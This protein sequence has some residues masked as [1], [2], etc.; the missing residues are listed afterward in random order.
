MID[1]T[2][3]VIPKHL[4]ALWNRRF[5][6]E[7]T[8][9]Y[10]QVLRKSIASS[11]KDD[12]LYLPVSLVNLA[13]KLE[14]V[15]RDLLSCVPYAVCPTCQ[16]EATQACLMCKKRGFLSKTQWNVCVPQEMKEIRKAMQC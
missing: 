11:W 9:R 12:P 10:V 6:V 7:D 8:L 3:M 4:E 13:S 5:E 1:L 15:Y 16:G 2:G 14:S